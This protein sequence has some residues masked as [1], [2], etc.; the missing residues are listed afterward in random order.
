M[1]VN[2]TRSF[3]FLHIDKKKTKYFHI[4]WSISFS[5]TYQNHFIYPAFRNVFQFIFSLFLSFIRQIKYLI[6]FFLFTLIFFFLQV[7]ETQLWNWTKKIKKKKKFSIVDYFNFVVWFPKWWW[8]SEKLYLL[9]ISSGGARIEIISCRKKN[10]FGSV[11]FPQVMFK[12]IGMY[13]VL[14]F[15][16]TLPASRLFPLQKLHQT[17]KLVR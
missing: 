12:C 8:V 9:N 2:C 13:A 11:S 16:A 4:E 7:S 10:Q 1:G 3:L 5:P 17:V 15:S 14:F 6:T